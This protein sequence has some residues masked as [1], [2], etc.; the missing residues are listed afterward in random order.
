M[1]FDVV[2]FS[3]PFMDRAKVPQCPGTATKFRF[4]ND[5]IVQFN[6]TDIHIRCL[7]TNVPVINEL[8]KLKETA[9]LGH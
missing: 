2:P 8:I 6:T 5:L 1:F 9:E 7:K 4:N 3:A